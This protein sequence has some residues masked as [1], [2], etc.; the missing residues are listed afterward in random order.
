MNFLLSDDQT[1]V[2]SAVRRY[3]DKA[4]PSS[5]LH[6]CFDAEAGFD[7][8]LWR[9]FAQI[10]VT[11]IA[12]P[13]DHGGLGLKLI[14]L[15]LVA[16]AVGAAA[17]PVPFL[18]HA[19]A[20][21]A[22]A[23]AGSEE[24]KS[25]WLPALAEGS[26]LAT[27]AFADAG[28][29]QPEQWSLAS[30]DRLLG[31]KRHVFAADVADL[32]V[33]G[34]AGGELAVI[35]RNAAGLVVADEGGIDRTRRLF[36]LTLEGT[37]AERLPEGAVQS[38]RLRDAALVLLAADAYGGAKRCLD[39]AVEYAKTRQ[40]FGQ[41]IGRF[42][43]LKHQLANMAVEIEPARGLYWFAAYAFDDVQ[44]RAA[45]SAALAK[46]HLTDRALQLARDAVEAHGGIGY[47]WEYEL[48][49]WLK[50]AMLDYAW[51]GAPQEH[52]ARAADLAGW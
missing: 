41:V 34:L 14:D 15:A 17:A 4:L 16:E 51:L 46:A 45:H 52:R 21:L 47:T 8:E 2:Q 38:A 39:L 7:T 33:V 26:V 22:I 12:L 42:Q 1:E 50:R 24:Q 19:L 43:A 35:E 29:W 3:F 25:R 23:W 27:I 36:T 10:G 32:I 5:R 18:G 49:I 44:D 40:Q 48:H 28:G 11:A 6:R 20:S 9:G 31:S 13:E 37:P 30:A